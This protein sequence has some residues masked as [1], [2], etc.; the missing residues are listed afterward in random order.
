L[1]KVWNDADMPRRKAVF[2]GLLA[3]GAGVAVGANWPK[4]SN[5]FGY[6]MT[7]L[8]FELADLAVW[9]WDPEKSALAEVES[10]TPVPSK[11]K[12]KI[13]TVRTSTAYS[14]SESRGKK[15][16]AASKKSRR[17]PRR[18]FD[19]A[20]SAAAGKTKA[21]EP[22][23]RSMEFSDNRVATRV[24]SSDS[25]LGK[26]GES[27]RSLDRAIRSKSNTVDTPSIRKGKASSKA[28][29]LA[30]TSTS[31]IQ[32][33]GKIERTKSKRAGAKKNGK[34]SITVRR[35]STRVLAATGSPAAAA[36]N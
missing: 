10:R 34:T 36:L 23:I 17:P 22:W 19:P 16:G 1:A 7:R 20:V 33:D 3:F 4:A 27:G 29:K 35:A 15:T 24:K 5:I 21:H 30:D 31:L 14:A 11:T 18:Q 8:G 13:R 6:I 28:T 12:N 26:S 25:L 32:P 9:A 2:T